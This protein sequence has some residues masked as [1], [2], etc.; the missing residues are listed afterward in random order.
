MAASR[1]GAALVLVAVMLAQ[2]HAA[3]SVHLIDTAAGDYFLP[4][5]VPA[6]VSQ[7][8]LTAMLASLLSLPYRMSAAAAEQVRRRRNFSA[9]PVSIS[10]YIIRQ[11]VFAG[12]S[13][14]QSGPLQAAASLGFHP[15][16]RS[17]PWCDAH[18]A[19]ATLQLGHLVHPP[20]L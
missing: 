11:P 9:L 5:S 6:E 17:Q 14:N 19:K 18:A 10:R 7:E 15:P 13:H 8:G 1:S 4:A 2:G 20:C 3:P 16:G 12:G